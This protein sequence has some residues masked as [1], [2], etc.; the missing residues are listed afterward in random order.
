MVRFF[1]FDHA[2][3]KVHMVIDEEKLKN[4]LIDT[5]IL[6]VEDITSFEK[7]KKLWSDIPSICTLRRYHYRQNY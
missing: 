3:I 4:L 6:S 7:Q 5:K 1:V 2:T